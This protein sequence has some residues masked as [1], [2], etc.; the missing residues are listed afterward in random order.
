[1]EM[2]LVNLRKTNTNTEIYAENPKKKKPR[3]ERERG[4]RFH[5]DNSDYNGTY[6]EC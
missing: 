5:Y 6:L 2:G 1:M 3:R 4:E